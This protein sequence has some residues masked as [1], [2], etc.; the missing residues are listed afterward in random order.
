MVGFMTNNA[1]LRAASLVD[2]L[3]VNVHLSALATSYANVSW[4]MSDL[5]YLGLDHVRDAAL[6]PTRVQTAYGTLANSGIHFDLIMSP[7]YNLSDT[8]SFVLAHP[9][10]VTTIEGPNEINITPISY[11]GLT[12]DAAGV[13]YMS[14]LT[15]AVQSDPTLSGVQVENLTKAS[16]VLGTSA[17]MGNLHIYS[18]TVQPGACLANALSQ[19]YAAM[20]GA[21]FAIS[22]GGFFTQPTLTGGVDQITQ[23]K[24]TL[25]LVMDAFKAGASNLYL[26][27]LLDQ[28]ADP[29]G[30]DPEQHYGLFD[31][32]NNPKLAAIGLHNLTTILSDSGANAQSF[33]TAAINYSVSGLS[34]TGSSLLLEKSSGAYDV[35]VWDEPTIW[36]D[37]THTAVAAPTESVSVAL[38]ATYATVNVF[39]PLSGA[40]PIAT[41]HNVQSVNLSVTDHPLIIEVEPDQSGQAPV[42]GFSEALA[43]DTGSSATDFL[44]NNGKVVLTGIASAGAAVTID[45]GSAAIG[46]AVADASGHWSFQ[47]T[48][49]AGSHQLSAV[50]TR[51]G[52]SSTYLAN[53]TIVVKTAAAAPV[54]SSVTGG[55]ATIASGGQVFTGKLSL[56][57]TAEANDVVTVYVDGARLGT[58]QANSTGQWSYD[59]SASPLTAGTH[60]FSAT[61]L[62][63][64]GNTSSASAPFSVAVTP[65]AVTLNL[66][67][68]HDNG[69]S[70]TDFVTNNGAIQTSGTATAGAQIALY[71]GSTLLGSTTASSTGTWSFNSTLSGQGVHQLSATATLNG[72]SSTY[73]NPQTV[74]LDTTAPAAPAV[75]S[76]TSG[77]A[78]L[79]ANAVNPTGAF[80]VNGTA[81]A[82]S[83]VT[84]FADGVKVGVV[85]AGATGAWSFDDTA[86]PLANGAHAFTAQAMD[87]AGNTGATSSGFNVTVQPPAPA[88]SMGFALVHD[89]GISASDFVTNNG[90]IQ[91][92]GTATAGA[93]VALY[94]GATL[95]G[96]TTASSTGTWS[97]NSTLSGQ[98]VH[99]LSATATLNGVSSTYANPQ[100]VTLDTTAPAAPAVTSLT[101]G[102]ATLAAN[103]VNPTGAFVVNGTAEANSQVTVFADGVKVG[104]VQAG[105]TGA[106]SFDDTAKP[107]ANG[108]HAF[109]AQAMDVAG[110]TG[111]TSS[112]FNVTVQPPAPAISMGFALV[113]DNGISASDFITN[114]GAIQTSGT[115]TAGAQIALY[116]GS[117]LLGST[118]ASSTG[119]WSFNTTLAGQGVHQLSATATLNGVSSTYVN[120][121]TVT[122][123]TTAPVAPTITQANEING[124]VQLGGLGASGDILTLNATTTPVLTTIGAGGVWSASFA[125]PTSVT[126]YHLYEMDTAGNLSPSDEIVVGTAGANTLT[127]QHAGDV[128]IGG[129]GGDTYV[130]SNTTGAGDVI[131]GF[132]SGQDHLQFT[133]FA[134]GAHLTQIDQTH[135]QI[136]DGVTTEG[137]QI[138]SGASLSSSDWILV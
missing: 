94:D 16:A 103:A 21:P 73:A 98:G 37:A 44:T 76:L 70:A 27:E 95:L 40:T 89:N 15:G 134:S 129:G 36:T 97:F 120:P 82:N 105:A 125:A 79:A 5:S 92:N 123:D 101:S 42:V 71:D 41:L 54:I 114:N 124:Q 87:V 24:L 135:W 17:P 137:F 52:L 100:T 48:L 4:V 108:A 99:Q 102:G 93:K 62:D 104:V 84:V 96:S 121:Q 39:D 33:S 32:N 65:P 72:V 122:L 130:L 59:D 29:T 19:Q 55:S 127:A 47:S 57:G 14:W 115:A 66:S 136:S 20:P 30:T 68:V 56:A 31:V 61:A 86:K 43:Q 107:L 12:G 34:S 22:E 69:I 45:D 138:A 9:G 91:T 109:T 26:Y 67:L 23:A 18:H 128:L 13:S 132:V 90:A 35:A 2:S 38:G 126:T 113:H 64:A 78:T 83:Q 51:A 6:S 8:D 112:G 11:N 117:T 75:T 63:T 58:A 85:Q 106:W 131:E 74:T 80:V 1:P 60:S 53:Q 46:S 25:N 49:G 50:A 77:G 3:G 133:G 28:S 118:T 10:A 116:D 7:G 110:N 111:A 81:E 119:A 88:I